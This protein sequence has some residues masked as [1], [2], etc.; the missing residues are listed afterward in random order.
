M[1]ICEV[2]NS[3]IGYDPE[4]PR[5]FWFLAGR[6]TRE[7]SVRAPNLPFLKMSMWKSAMTAPTSSVPLP[8]SRVVGLKAFHTVLSQRLVAMK[9][10][11]PC[12]RP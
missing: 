5:T 12:P 3:L 1:G 11:V 8:V 9:S 4:C 10:E 7:P 2:Q 6:S